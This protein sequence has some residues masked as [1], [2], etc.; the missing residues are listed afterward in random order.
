MKY[1]LFLFVILLSC[2]KKN[3]SKSNTLN[4]ALSDEVRTLDP[5]KSYDAI[6]AKI[7]Y[8]VLEPLYQYHYHKRPYTLVPLVADGMPTIKNSGKTYIIKIK[9]NISYHPHVVFGNRTRYLKAQD[10]ITQI[11]RLAFIKTGS[12]GWWLFD[13]KIKGIN[14]FRKNAKTVEDIKSQTIEGLTALDDHTLRIDLNSPYPQMLFA[15]AMSFTS[16]MPIEIVEKYNNRLNDVLIGTG[17]YVLKKWL[18]MS[19]LILEKN[20]SYNHDVY[21]SEGDRYAHANSLLKD[22][23]RKLPFIDKINFKIIK[24]GQTQW[25]NF[26]SG[27]ID[28]LTLPKDKYELA[29][30]AGRLK[31]EIKKKN[32]KLQ[33]SPTLTY[34]WLSFSMEDPLLGK[35]IFLRKAIAHAFDTEKFITRFTNNI[36]QKANSIFPPGTPGYNPSRKLPYEYNLKKA[37][38]Y[39]I[40]AGYPGGKGLPEFNFDVRGIATLNRQQGEFLTQQMSLIGLKINFVTNTFPE[41]LRKSEQ[42]KLQFWQDG[43]SMDYPDAENTLQLLTK[44]SHS[45]GPNSTMYHNPKFEELYS[46]LKYLKNG[47]E[48]YK[49]MEQMEDI[50]FKDIPWVMQYYTRSYI[51]FYDHVSNFRNSDIINNHF[52]YLRIKK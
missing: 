21:P 50:I 14:K 15:L 23:D 36:G 17:P 30:E 18:R 52:K 44:K 48:K 19:S 1:I 46:K 28:V 24:E 5:A 20:P 13:G 47:E 33:I 40:K 7:I 11:K 31:D 10:F 26:L 8:Q 4:Y 37:K 35:N 12:N 9:K 29:V 16:P 41:F 32:I 3:Q 25:F 6:S 43:W 42:R 34:W 2:Q 49:I 27:K 38:E 39:L 45:P 51:L 22:A